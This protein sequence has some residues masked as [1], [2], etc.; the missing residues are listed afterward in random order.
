[1]VATVPV[2]PF[3]RGAWYLNHGFEYVR[4]ARGG[5]V[6][7]G[8][9]RRASEAAETGFLEYPTAGVQGALE[10]FVQE[11]YPALADRPIARRWAGV[12]AFTPDGLPRIGSAPGMPGV[13]YA[14]GF[15]GHGMSLGFV[16]GRHLA[17]LAA[18]ETD[19]PLLPAAHR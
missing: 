9:G 6:V 7:L 18:G 10:R 12:M 16:T 19:T 4:Q 1:M 13:V 11:S 14:A 2:D 17:R 8:G 5:S 15:N 3:I